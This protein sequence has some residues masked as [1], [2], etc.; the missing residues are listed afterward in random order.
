[1]DLCQ[2]LIQKCLAITFYQ[3]QQQVDAGT[4]MLLQQQDSPTLC[5]L[6]GLL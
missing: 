1:M 4:L 2:Y 6:E 3:Q 5:K